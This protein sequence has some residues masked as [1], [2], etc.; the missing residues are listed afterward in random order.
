MLE[1]AW[2]DR[3][4][5]QDF[6]LGLEQQSKEREKS[7]MLALQVDKRP[8][9]QWSAAPI[10]QRAALAPPRPRS[11]VVRARIEANRAFRRQEV[12]S[13]LKAHLEQC[14]EQQQ[15]PFFHRELY[16]A[17]FFNAADPDA[18]LQ[19]AELLAQGKATVQ[20]IGDVLH[21]RQLVIL[22][23]KELDAQYADGL[24]L[25]EE[26]RQQAKNF[27][28]QI[29]SLTLDVVDAVVRWRTELSTSEDV[30][31]W[32][33]A[34]RGPGDED[35]LQCLPFELGWLANSA[36]AELIPFSKQADPF[37]LFC[38]S[39]H[40]LTSQSRGQPMKATARQ[41]KAVARA[42]G[43]FPIL[44]QPLPKLP[45]QHKHQRIVRSYTSGPEG[46]PSRP[47]PTASPGRSTADIPGATRPIPHA[48]RARSSPAGPCGAKDGVSDL[49]SLGDD[50]SQ[51]SRES[52]LSVEHQGRARASQ[53]SKAKSENDELVPLTRAEAVRVHA[54][55]LV[56]ADALAARRFDNAAWTKGVRATQRPVSHQ[57]SDHEEE[58]RPRLPSSQQEKEKRHNALLQQASINIVPVD[59]LAR[60]TLLLHLT[61]EFWDRMNPTVTE[62][63]GPKKALEEL[64]TGPLEM[65]HWYWLGS[66]TEDA[67]ASLKRARETLR[68]ASRGEAAENSFSL[69]FTPV[70]LLAV[71][72]PTADQPD[73]GTCEI[74]HLSLA[75]GYNPQTVAKQLRQFLL[76]DEVQHTV[77]IR[78]V[79]VR[80]RAAL[81]D[82]ELISA[83]QTARYRFF[84]RDHADDG[85]PCAVMQTEYMNDDFEP[86]GRLTKS[87]GL[88]LR[89]GLLIEAASKIEGL[90]KMPA[91][92]FNAERYCPLVVEATSYGGASDAAARACAQGWRVRCPGLLA[93][94]L[95]SAAVK[96]EARHFT[97][98]GR[99]S[100]ERLD[101]AFTRPGD[102]PASDA[103][104]ST[105]LADD[106]ALAEEIAHSD[107]LQS[108][109]RSQPTC[110]KSEWAGWRHEASRLAVQHLGK[111]AAALNEKHEE[112][113]G[114]VPGDKA[115]GLQ[116]L[117]LDAHWQW[118]GLAQ[119]EDEEDLVLPVIGRSGNVRFVG[120]SDPSGEFIVGVAPGLANGIF[121]GRRKAMIAASGTIRLQ[122]PA[123]GLC[124]RGGEYT[125][126]NR[127]PTGE[128]QIDALKLGVAFELSLADVA[129]PAPGLLVDASE[130]HVS[131]TSRRSLDRGTFL[132]QDSRR[133]SEQSP[134]ARAGTWP[135][136]PEDQPPGR[137]GPEPKAGTRSTVVGC[138]PGALGALPVLKPVHMLEANALE[139]DE[140]IEES[141]SEVEDDFEEVSDSGSESK[142][143]GETQ[144]AVGKASE[145]RTVQD[146]AVADYAGE[147]QADVAEPTSQLSHGGP[148]DDVARVDSE[149]GHIAEPVASIAQVGTA[150]QEGLDAIP[151]RP[152]E[153]VSRKA[154]AATDDFEDEF[155]PVSEESELGGSGAESDSDSSP[156]MSEEE[157]LLQRPFCIAVWHY[158]LDQAPLVVFEAA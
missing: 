138:L 154:S 55:E 129:E 36:L 25:A 33:V 68:R 114:K 74:R 149:P 93:A 148:L 9:Q 96:L 48:E 133:T 88:R 139:V 103:Q 105:Q 79:R 39:P 18:L 97:K 121:H 13:R 41:F 86:S 50:T 106:L 140:R 7:R 89:V 151:D 66:A 43:T 69:G 92:R 22:R 135:S 155:E 78:Q 32:R 84:R 29:R 2:D 128:P 28:I 141:E 52:Y 27:I 42:P 150:W 57:E 11:S 65:T 45:P 35:L 156:S 152:T 122:T 81:V 110:I 126:F 6:S 26:A 146:E 5:V 58:K 100:K 125:S 95:R 142:T 127:G 63:L 23:M 130:A 60:A 85:A 67:V 90:I 131:P 87:P 117:E 83:F 64:L 123:Q 24:V 82:D 40:A 134:P 137:Q 91:D 44:P 30:P 8:T 31:S 4:H 104:L 3:F 34:T 124:I 16:A 49:E 12:T 14:W 51:D 59:G 119:P 77:P 109:P 21:R 113:A 143:V 46:T 37:L 15:V 157:A 1:Q 102:T 17:R 112:D 62:V 111:Q 72:L 98:K 56:L 144:D 38:S 116:Q 108:W 80:M 71:H 147:D 10:P 94:G 132:R 158:D 54:A 20:A 99:P 115:G 153:P 19:E 136:P 145:S 70:G 76:T 61:D 101:S 118:P 47:R 120:T 73:A 53:T 107:A 75:K